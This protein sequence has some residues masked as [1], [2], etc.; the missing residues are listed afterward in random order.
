MW[1]PGSTGGTN[2]PG[3][4]ACAC[5]VCNR[6]KGDL[7]LKQLGWELLPIADRGDWDGLTRYYPALWELAG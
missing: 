6:V 3:N 4:F 5:W 2:A 7:T 1:S